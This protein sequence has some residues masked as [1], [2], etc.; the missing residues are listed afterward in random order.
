M[1]NLENSLLQFETS[2]IYFSACRHKL[3][4]I[5]IAENSSL[6]VCQQSYLESLY[7]SLLKQ[8]KFFS[9]APVVI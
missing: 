6:A 1:V 5:Q 4:A 2:L 8:M 3:M 9:V 7:D